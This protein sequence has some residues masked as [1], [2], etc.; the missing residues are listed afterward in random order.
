MT[1]KHVKNI[2][3]LLLLVGSL[4][5][6]IL[7][8]S[9]SLAG[10][11]FPS[12]E[13]TTPTTQAANTAMPAPSA[14]PDITTFDNS[15]PLAVNTIPS[16][17]R[18]HHHYRSRHLSRLAKE[19]E[20]ENSLAE[21]SADDLNNSTDASASNEVASDTSDNNYSDDYPTRKRS[22]G[23]LWDSLKYGFQLDHYRNDPQVQAQIAWYMRNQGY[24][25]RTSLRAAPYMYYI[26]QQVKERNLPTE[27]VLLPIMESAYN[28]F[29]A[30][31]RGAAGLWQ[32]ER[33]TA[34]QFGVKQDFW[35][36]GRRDVLAS[37]NAALD[38]LTYLQSFFGGNWLLAIA[39]YDAGEGSIQEA[40][41][42]NAREG[43]NINFW[44]L[45]LPEET[46]AYIPR[47]LALA[48]IIEDPSR[49]GI[50]LPPISNAPYLGAVDIGGQINLSD[51][52]NYAGISLDELK[53]LNPGF[54][55]RTT[56][57][58]GP[59]KLLLPFDSI[60][61]FQE[62]L[63][64]FSK[65]AGASWTHYK[66]RA[67]DTIE[68]IARNFDT[69]VDMLKLVNHLHS[70][71][72]A[73]GKRLLIPQSSAGSLG[74][75]TVENNAVGSETT[76]AANNTTTDNSSANV[77]NN[78]S[79]NANNNATY[80]ANNT[81]TVSEAS[82]AGVTNA[83]TASSSNTESGTNNSN[84]SA[85]ATDNNTAA[86]TTAVNNNAIVPLG[87]VQHEKMRETH[88]MKRGE[89]LQSIAAHYHVSTKDLMKWNKI[90][91]TRS[92]KPG[93]KI[94]IIYNYKI[95]VN[96][97]DSQ[98][99][100][101]TS[102][103]V[104]VQTNNNDVIKN[105]K[106]KKKSL[107]KNT[108]ARTKNNKANQSKKITP[109]IATTTTNK[110]PTNKS[111]SAAAPTN[112]NIAHTAAVVTPVNTTK[113]KSTAA[114]PTTVAITSKSKTAIV[115][116]TPNSKKKTKHSTVPTHLTHYTI[117][118]GD[119]LISIA[120]QYHVDAADIK[121]W[122]HLHKNETLHGGNKLLIYY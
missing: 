5:A 47:L 66:V 99:E 20:L 3:S 87:S 85:V 96:A 32:L 86:S 98:S 17:P 7:A 11:L 50:N 27:L 74:S 65:N 82:D 101:N 69:S 67:G 77:E 28:P 31:N 9:T 83:N 118:N 57:P 53:Q 73:V 56:D 37:T 16:T 106:I 114:T 68:S 119:T 34:S 97:T 113:L 51:V 25:Y 41:R 22:S 2:I 54:N 70:R 13:T 60:Q 116:T 38:Y 112:I 10:G 48:C 15:A 1:I 95:N 40:V 23:N 78:T 33:G 108:I 117:K 92:I 29:A 44:S 59:H 105:H 45:S 19:K 52:A 81:M 55:H 121:K 26:Y 102:P 109:V 93:K 115:A 24:L 49:Y 104:V 107:K 94:V 88:I 64:K 6:S 79:T 120:H 100:V 62:N 30:S 91:H 42:R 103:T 36:D 35:Y 4:M 12:N 90:K 61:L 84:N 72:I 80:A 89:T 63:L 18:H 43:L 58:D 75:A 46:R 14:S 21:N 39:A 8:P 111:I 71:E 110:N 122:N 76:L